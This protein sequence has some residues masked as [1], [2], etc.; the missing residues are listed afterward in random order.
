MKVLIINSVCGFGS[1]GNIVSNIW[2]TA[3]SKGITIKIAYGVGDARFV[4]ISDVYKIGNKTDYYIHNTLSRITDKA[5]FYS[6]KNTKKLLRYIDKYNP[7]IIHLNNLHGYYLNVKLLFNFLSKKRIKVIWTLHDCWAITGHCV[8]FDYVKCDKWKT[9]CFDCKYSSEYPISYIKDRSEKNYIEKKNLFT[10]IKDM[11]ITVPSEWLRTIVNQSYLNKYPIS[12][13][14]NGIDLNVFRFK[15]SDYR[16]KYD[17]VQKKIVL[18]VS[19]VWSEKKGL[20]DI[21]ELSKRLKNKYKLVV[22]GLAEKQKLLF[23]NNTLLFNRTNNLDELVKWYSVAD[24]FINPSYEETMG[25]T[26][27]EALACGTPAVVYNRTAVPEAICERNGII[28]QAGD[29]EDMLNAIENIVD[30]YHKYETRSSVK[31]I[32]VKLINQRWINLYRELI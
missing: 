32:D 1:T 13:I 17:I 6:T 15:K 7:D 23:N 14:P 30:N 24:V 4:D 31:K 11:Y 27:Y 9:K 26:T 19:S 5:S 25:M 2:K 20:N 3:K 28:V 10:S 29:I 18:A 22:I 12:V 8:H 21:V 16:E